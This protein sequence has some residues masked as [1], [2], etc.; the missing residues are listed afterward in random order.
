MSSTK[1]HQKENPFQSRHSKSNRRF[2]EP[3]LF[4]ALPT[5]TT[6]PPANSFD[7]LLSEESQTQNQTSNHANYDVRERASKQ[8]IEKCIKW[9]SKGSDGQD[10]CK[11]LCLLREEDQTSWNLLK[12]LSL[13]YSESSDNQHTQISPNNT[14]VQNQLTRVQGETRIDLSNSL[15]LLRDH[16]KKILNPGYELG[17]R[18][19]ESFKDG[20]QM[21]F[22]DRL[23]ENIKRGEALILA[24]ASILKMVETLRSERK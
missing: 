5:F 4:T 23:K 14:S 9:C 10:S 12:A 13:Q 7:H 15:Y 22:F 3:T 24:K 21:A 20:T 19:V 2:D 17:C 6:E 18:Y 16:C 1:E 11:S 8:S